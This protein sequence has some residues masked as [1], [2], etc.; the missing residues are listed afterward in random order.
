MHFN[1]HGGGS[2]WFY[3]IPMTIFVISAITVVIV[4]LLRSS[5]KQGKV[6]GHHEHGEKILAERY[7]KGEIDNEEYS[8]RL[9]TLRDNVSK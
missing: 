6:L 5:G 4:V 3:M 2:Y 9:K 7:A 8:K 1:E